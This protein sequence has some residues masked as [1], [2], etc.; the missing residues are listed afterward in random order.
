MNQA[1]TCSAVDPDEVLLVIDAMMG[2]D[3]VD[4]AKAFDEGVDFTGVVLSKL[5]GDARGGAALSVH[6]GDRQAHHVHLHG[7]G[8]ADFEQFH[9]DR[10]ASASWTWVTS[11]RSSA[12]RAAVGT[13]PRPSG[14]PRISPTRAHVEDFLAQMQDGWLAQDRDP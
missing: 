8:R 14:W 13:R 4:A 3:A 1:R 7:R 11:S 10:M 9:P 6:R 12:G 5:D 2:Q